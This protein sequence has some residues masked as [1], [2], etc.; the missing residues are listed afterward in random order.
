MPCFDIQPEPYEEDASNKYSIYMSQL[1]GSPVGRGSGQIG[2]TYLRQVRGRTIQCQM[3]TANKVVTRAPL[4]IARQTVFG[5]CNRFAKLHAASIKVSF[6]QTKYGSARNYFMQVNYAALKSA[7]AELTA[8][9]SDAAIEAAIK[10]Y[11][12][13]NPTEIYRVRR[14]GYANVYLKGE[15][16]SSDDPE[17]VPAGGGSGSGGSGEGSLDE[18]PLG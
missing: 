2:D 9:A 11:A 6:N 12:T 15:W 17:E 5:L 10:T 4:A 3:P 1:K 14:N 18:N 7:L 13:E 8:S 16:K